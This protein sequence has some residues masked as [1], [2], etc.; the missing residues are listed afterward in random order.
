MERRGAFQERA[1]QEV[2]S[3]VSVIREDDHFAID[4]RMNRDKSIL[5]PF[6]PSD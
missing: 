6:K 4:R 2:V 1:S 5:I 3:E